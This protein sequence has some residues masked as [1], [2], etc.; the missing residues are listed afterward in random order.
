MSNAIRLGSCV[1]MEPVMPFLRF[2]V[3]AHTNNICI[4]T[5][6]PLHC[7]VDG[8]PWL[9]E[10]GIMQIKFHSRNP[11][12]KKMKNDTTCDCMAIG[13]AEKTVIN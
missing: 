2:Q 11:I 3:A 12:L 6:C 1:A 4:R 10:E 13:Q 8:E 9:Q 5:R 7:Q